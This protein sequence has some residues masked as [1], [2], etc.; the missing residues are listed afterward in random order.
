MLSLG[1]YRTSIST[2]CRIHEALV[3]AAGLS[4]MQLVIHAPV[5]LSPPR[6]MGSLD[7]NRVY[8]IVYGSKYY[9]FIPILL[10]PTRN[11]E[12]KAVRYNGCKAYLAL[13]LAFILQALVKKCLFYT[14]LIMRKNCYLLPINYVFLSIFWLFI[15]KLDFSKAVV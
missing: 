15:C 14:L 10:N 8:P 5:S 3:T 13:L 1:L 9:V 6:Y 7:L 2:C 4:P 11:P 12:I